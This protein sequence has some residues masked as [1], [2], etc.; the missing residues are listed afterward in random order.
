[1]FLG[2]FLLLRRELNMFTRGSLGSLF[3][4]CSPSPFL[5]FSV[6]SLQWLHWGQ[7]SEFE[8]FVSQLLLS[9]LQ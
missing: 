9:D 1:M 7:D 4:L 6:V 5:P 3:L 2:I 8:F